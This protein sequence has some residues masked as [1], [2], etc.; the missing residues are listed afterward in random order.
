MSNRNDD[1]L[2]LAILGVSIGGSVVTRYVP[3]GCVVNV[4]VFIV[5]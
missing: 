3:A 1:L 4:C 2:Y 5:Y